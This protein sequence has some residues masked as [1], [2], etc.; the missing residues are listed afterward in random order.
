MKLLK[1]DWLVLSAWGAAVGVGALVCGLV[2]PG[3]WKV[4]GAVWLSGLALAALVM[5]AYR[6][7]ALHLYHLHEQNEEA[8]RRETRQ[9]EALMKILLL[10]KPRRLLPPLRGM[11]ISPDFAALLVDTILAKKPRHIVELGCGASTI[12]SSY[13]L[14]QLGEGGRVTSLDHDARFSEVCRG[15]LAEH[16]LAGIATIYDCPLREQQVGG[17]T[18]QYYDLSR[19]QLPEEIDLLVIDGPPEWIAPGVRYPALPL[20]KERLSARAVVL[21]DDAGRENEKVTVGRW[22]KEFAGWEHRF[23]ELEKG[24]SLLT[25][26]S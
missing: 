8:Q 5:L 15:Q 19:A 7:L 20:L 14:E 3:P 23:V 11:A 25:R 22:L 26:V 9:T 17:K 12:I 21:L 6:N 24:A 16:G 10:V 2:F 18:W 13:V 4:V 1:K